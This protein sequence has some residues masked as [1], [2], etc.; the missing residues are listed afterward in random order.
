MG[1]RVMTDVD[2]YLCMAIGVKLLDCR[3]GVDQHLKS[4]ERY[5]MIRQ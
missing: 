3:R 4:K 1:K 5:K 2:S